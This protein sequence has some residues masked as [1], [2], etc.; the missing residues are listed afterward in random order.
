MNNFRKLWEYQQGALFLKEENSSLEWRKTLAEYFYESGF[1]EAK[2]EQSKIA[3]KLWNENEQLKDKLKTQAEII[4]KLELLKSVRETLALMS[5][6][7]GNNIE[8]YMQMSKSALNKID[9]A[10]SCNVFLLFQS[11]YLMKHDING[12]SRNFLSTK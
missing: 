6:G 1:Y 7:E 11:K 12:K 8:V 9:K 3:V 10:C 2:E 4:E 5:E